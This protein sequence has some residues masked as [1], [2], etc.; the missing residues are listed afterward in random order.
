MVL[1]SNKHCLLE[2]P[3][4]LSA[5]DARDMM[6]LAKLKGRFLGEGMWTRYFPAVEMVRELISNGEIGGEGEGG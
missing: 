4:A 6:E 2:K 3:M 5:K 1:N